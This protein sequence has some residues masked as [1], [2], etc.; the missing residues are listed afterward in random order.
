MT[1]HYLPLCDLCAHDLDLP[2]L[3]HLRSARFED[4]IRAAPR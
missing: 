4:G 1:D 3:L 2:E